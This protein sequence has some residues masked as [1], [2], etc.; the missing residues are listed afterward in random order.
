MKKEK[1]DGMTLKEIFDGMTLKELV[2]DFPDDKDR[3]VSL[4]SNGV[5]TT[6]SKDDVDEDFGDQIIKIVKQSEN[7]YDLLLREKGEKYPG[8][9]GYLLFKDNVDRIWV[10]TR[11]IQR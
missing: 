2:G 4:T 1:T 9:F 11:N 3:D 10:G 5:Y 8:E 6:L 7:V